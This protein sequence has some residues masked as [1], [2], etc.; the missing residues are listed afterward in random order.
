M[1]I[2]QR[3]IILLIGYTTAYVVLAMICVITGYAIMA[4]IPIFA[5]FVLLITSWKQFIINMNVER[6][7]RDINKVINNDITKNEDDAV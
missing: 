3:S 4:I 6:H 5:L 7:I 2:H 1:N